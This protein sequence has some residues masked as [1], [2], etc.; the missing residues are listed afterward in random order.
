MDYAAAT[1]I[2][3]SAEYNPFECVKTNVLGAMNLIDACIDQEIEK[4][5]ALSTD[6]ASG[7]I[8]LYGATKLTA[9]KL[10]VARMLILEN[11][12]QNSQL[13]GME[14]SWDLVGQSYLSSNL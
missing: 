12:K 1:K 6:K 10:F 11:I 3:P 2:V 7:P 8:N 13:L 4:V 9:D 14:M 5:I